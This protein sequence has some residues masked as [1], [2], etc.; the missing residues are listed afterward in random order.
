MATDETVFESDKGEV[1]YFYQHEYMLYVTDIRI[2]QMAKRWKD[3][4][5]VA[6]YWYSDGRV[7]NQYKIPAKLKKRAIA[8]LKGTYR[9]KGVDLK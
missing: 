4:E 6:T 3:A 9:N 1:W 8:A 5:H 7:C 2:N